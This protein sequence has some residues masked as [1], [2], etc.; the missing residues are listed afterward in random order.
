MHGLGNLIVHEPVIDE[1]TP[2]DFSYVLSA[3]KLMLDERMQRHVLYQPDRWQEQW[4]SLS[5]N[6]GDVHKRQRTIT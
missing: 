4:E 5:L 2:D 1:L 3:S 6:K